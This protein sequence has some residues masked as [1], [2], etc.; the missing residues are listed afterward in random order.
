MKRVENTGRRENSGKFFYREA[1]KCF[2]INMLFNPW[3]GYATYNLDLIFACRD[4][5]L[6][7]KVV[8]LR[9]LLSFKH[10]HNCYFKKVA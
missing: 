8:I 6:S 3:V 4:I 5:V 10:Q 9:D 7:S 2:G 1:G